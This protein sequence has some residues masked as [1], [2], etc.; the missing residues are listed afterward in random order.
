MRWFLDTEFAEDGKVIELISIALVAE[1]GRFY[2]AVA[3]DGWAPER[4][5]EWV[6]GNVLPHLPLDRTPRADI[7]DTVKDILLRDGKPEIWGYFADYDWVVLCQL[8]GRMVD[9]PKGF[10]FYCMD[11]K[12]LMRERGIE[13]SDLPA[14]KGTEHDALADARWIREAWLHIHDQEVPAPNT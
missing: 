13:K 2:Y 7:A 6:K 9:L 1:D 12:Q 8:F 3:A 5:N 10:P 11:L 4:C 14:Q